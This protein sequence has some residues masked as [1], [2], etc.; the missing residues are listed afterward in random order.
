MVKQRISKVFQRWQTAWEE[1]FGA[2]KNKTDFSKST[3]IDVANFIKNARRIKNLPKSY[4][5][6]LAQEA[7]RVDNGWRSKNNPEGPLRGEQVIE[8]SLLEAKKVYVKDAHVKLLGTATFSKQQVYLMES[9]GQVK[10]DLVGSFCFVKKTPHV[11]SFEVKVDA[12]H[13]GYA[14]VECCRQVDILRRSPKKVA[15]LAGYASTTHSSWGAVIAPPEYY[16]D[17]DNMLKRAI[18]VAQL[19]LGTELR[20][21]FLKWESDEKV[22][23]YMGGN[24][25]V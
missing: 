1:A 19:L 16:K 24:W 11:V 21:A 17:T 2:V 23:I 6:D 22:L 12:N 8:K 25:P 14:L 4:I 5:R 15:A 10:P 20:V 9:Q 3:V 7:E 18:D 13:C